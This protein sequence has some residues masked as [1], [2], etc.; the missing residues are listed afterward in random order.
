M[1]TTD[2]DGMSHAVRQLLAIVALH[3]VAVGASGDRGGRGSRGG[4]VACAEAAWS[5]AW[6]SA[7]E[8]AAEGK[9][10]DGAGGVG[11][12]MWRAVL[13]VVGRCLGDWMDQGVLT[14][15]IAV[16]YV[17]ALVTD[18]V[19]RGS[20]EDVLRSMG[21]LHR[22]TWTRHGSCALED[23]P[24]HDGSSN[25]TTWASLVAMTAT[26]FLHD[27]ATRATE[28]RGQGL[29]LDV[30][31][32]EGNAWLLLELLRGVCVTRLRNVPLF[33]AGVRSVAGSLLDSIGVDVRHGLDETT[34]DA[35]L[36]DVILPSLSCCPGGEHQEAITACVQGLVSQCI[37]GVGRS[38]NSSAAQRAVTL[39]ALHVLVAVSVAPPLSANSVN[40][41]LEDTAWAVHPS[42]ADG[43]GNDATFPGAGGASDTVGTTGGDGGGGGETKS[44]GGERATLEAW[45]KKEGEARQRKKEE[46]KK[47]KKKN[48]QTP[49]KEAGKTKEKGAGKG[50]SGASGGRP[51]E[52]A[53]LI[54]SY[55]RGEPV[56]YKGNRGVV[57]KVHMNPHALEDVES[58][59]VRYAP[60]V[61][62]TALVEG[63][64][65][66]EANVLHGS[67]HIKP[68]WAS[69]PKQ[70]GEDGSDVDDNDDDDDDH[71]D[72]DTT[73]DEGKNN[74]GGGGV[75]ED[76]ELRLALALSMQEK[77]L[78]DDDDGGFDEDERG[79]DGTPS[80]AALAALV[81]E[82]A[83][84]R[85]A[86]GV[87]DGEDSGAL[88]ED[89]ARVRMSRGALLDAA[90]SV[91]LSG[92]EEGSG[93]E[94]AASPSVSLRDAWEGHSRASAVLPIMAGAACGFIGSNGFAND[95]AAIGLNQCR[96]KLADVCDPCCETARVGWEG[97]RQSGEVGGA[98]GVTAIAPLLPGS[99]MAAL[100]VLRVKA[101][102]EERLGLG[103]RCEKGGGEKKDQGNGDN[104]GDGFIPLLNVAVPILAS[105]GNGA[106]VGKGG[107]ASEGADVM[108][109]EVRCAAR[110]AVLRLS[111]AVLQTGAVGASYSQGDLERLVRV[112]IDGAVALSRHVLPLSS[113]GQ[114]A[115]GEHK[116][117]RGEGDEE[118]AGGGGVGGVG[119]ANGVGCGV[120]TAE[121]VLDMAAEACRLA[122][123]LFEKRSKGHGEAA[124]LMDPDPSAAAARRGTPRAAWELVDTM[125]SWLDACHWAPVPV[126]DV[127][128][129]MGSIEDGGAGYTGYSGFSRFRAVGAAVAGVRAALCLLPVALPSS[130]GDDL[131]WWEDAGRS[132]RIHRLVQAPSPD[133]QRLTFLFSRA[134]IIMRDD[135]AGGR[136]GVGVGAGSSVEGADAAGAAAVEEALQRVRG[137]VEESFEM[138]HADMLSEAEEEEARVQ[139]VRSEYVEE[140]RRRETSKRGESY[141]VWGRAGAVGGRQRATERYR[142]R[143]RAIDRDRAS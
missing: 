25:G 72:D 90:L 52:G 20:S 82:E 58:Y 75:G 3:R 99:T 108:D 84:L 80:S 118:T 70:E 125:T 54:K 89:G 1:H 127:A 119:G 4:V 69:Q 12:M 56:F 29:F 103:A 101:D 48:K 51:G 142:E 60:P 16:L 124:A 35:L 97:A 106:W 34:L 63:D 105:G 71:D 18:R 126:A 122:R 55:R 9:D 45:A 96:Q 5:A 92:H 38:S 98:A 27:Q 65:A 133:V 91:V 64:G 88:G 15:D 120:S 85:G 86:A 33:T 11:G 83:A 110:A 141:G 136:G 7:G 8:H 14:A 140:K 44:A 138:N 113:H 42:A 94:R 22:P 21:L 109:L 81:V 17:S 49:K 114:A 30:L 31:L 100:H 116:E 137:E 66:R 93:A 123:L 129:A 62:A 36:N 50:G 37:G 130:M 135:L 46:R 76:E 112:S 107:T 95:A 111:R 78:F 77:G 128:G 115:R 41:L 57:M 32:S 87:A 59:T 132:D 139:R 19:A 26:I 143:W 79:N 121:A 23:T 74:G 10:G 40:S 67:S 131:A 6:Q 43:A 61:I 39:G 73:D 117:A 24:T 2:D 104:D 13:G 134:R 68:I 28:G 102:L 47:K 53:P